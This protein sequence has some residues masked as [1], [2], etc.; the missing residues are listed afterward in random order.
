MLSRDGKLTQS[1]VSEKVGLSLSA[2]QRRIK[3]LERSGVITGYKAVIDPSHLGED[4]VVF[5]GI[6]LERHTREAAR[7]FEAAVTSLPMVKEIYHVAGEY[8][9]LIKVAVA[10]IAAYQDFNFDYLTE[11]PGMGK[12]TSFIT[13]SDRKAAQARHP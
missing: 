1:E 12:I 13:L 7:S 5:V 3:A 2:C 10:D 8:D 4:L 9:Y 6:N 11:I